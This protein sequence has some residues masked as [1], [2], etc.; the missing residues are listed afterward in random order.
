MILL[1]Y[2]VRVQSPI[3]PEPF[4]HKRF[5]THLGASEYYS[6]MQLINRRFE[7]RIYDRKKG[8]YIR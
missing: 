6:K 5:F 3:D 2:E 1:R 8:R 4:I 7:V